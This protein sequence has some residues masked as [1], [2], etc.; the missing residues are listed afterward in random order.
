LIGLPIVA[1]THTH[2]HTLALCREQ[3]SRTS[4]R[5]PTA[6]ITYYR[7]RTAIE[8]LKVENTVCFFTVTLVFVRTHRVKWPS[9]LCSMLPPSA[10]VTPL[11]AL[12]RRVDIVQ[13]LPSPLLFLYLYLFI[14]F[15]LF[16]FSYF[17]ISV[18]FRSYIIIIIRPLASQHYYVS[19]SYY[20]R[21]WFIL[22][23]NSIVRRSV[24]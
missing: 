1:L 19:L 9:F 24:L 15:V 13:T 21:Y 7:D 17:V 18:N 23:P 12:H 16:Y 14:T 10:D 22:I 4:S 5:K 8:Y 11:E 6:I 2:S 20:I 3:R